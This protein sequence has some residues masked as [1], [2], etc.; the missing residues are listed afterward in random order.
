MAETKK[1]PHASIVRV[2]P[3]YVLIFDGLSL[4]EAIQIADRAEKIIP[5]N[6]K[7]ALN[8]GDSITLEASIPRMVRG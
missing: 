5:Y 8:D 1:I 4:D 3:G 2:D 6:R 7:L